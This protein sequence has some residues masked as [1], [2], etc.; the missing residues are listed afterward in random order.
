MAEACVKALL[1]RNANPNLISYEMRL[2]LL[3]LAAMNGYESTRDLVEA[4][5]FNHKNSQVSPYLTQ[6]NGIR[7]RDLIES[8]LET[9]TR[10]S[11]RETIYATFARK[12]INEISLI[13]TFFLV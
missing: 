3:Y 5:R 4:G 13:L 12:Y 10:A 2:S 6:L 7:R 9:E 8:A 1:K 11:C